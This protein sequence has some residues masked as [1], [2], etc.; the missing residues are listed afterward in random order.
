MNK[1]HISQTMVPMRIVASGICCS[2]G[3]HS[4][5]ALAAIRARLNHFCESEFMDETGAPLRAA[6]LY[7][8]FVWGQQ[9]LQL[10][11]RSAM[12]EC[13]SVLPEKTDEQLPP[14]ILIGAEGER[15]E[16]FAKSMD[17]LLHNNTPVDGYDRHTQRISAGKAGIGQAL[18][19]ASQIFSELHPPE[20]VVIAGVD[21]YLDAAAITHYLQTQRL[22][23]ST[24]SDGFIPGEAGAAIALST[25]PSKRPA[26]WIEGI[27]QAHE[28]ASPD[29]DIPLRAQGLTKALR[30]ALT[31]AGREITD[32]GFHASGVS[33]EQWYFKEAS[34][35]IDRI[36]TTKVPGFPH[37]LISQSTG[38]IGAACGPLTLAW[39]EHEM[40]IDQALGRRGLLHFGNDNGTRCA[41]AVH[42]GT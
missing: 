27:G 6:M 11:Y 38:E 29:N 22:R 8:V 24:N 34:T 3:F 23:C 39:V 36:M 42:Y 14:V 41:L 10:M 21:S 30:H 28:A 33:G 32:Y 13:L 12:T 9:R 20:H 1:T 25:R 7:K 31:S 37:R 26:L 35:A 15:G 2:V 4:G 40:E 16:R 5:A 18:L 17:Q 19:M